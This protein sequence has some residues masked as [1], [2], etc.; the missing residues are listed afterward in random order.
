MNE[1]C[2]MHDDLLKVLL[3]IIPRTAYQDIRHLSTLA[4]AMTGLCLT[5][6]VR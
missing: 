5:H 2:Q 3:P 4:W 6:T 1:A